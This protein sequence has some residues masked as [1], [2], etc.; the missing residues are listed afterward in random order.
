[1]SLTSEPIDDSGLMRARL[2]SGATGDP[3]VRSD[4]DNETETLTLATG[5]AVPAVL[6][7]LTH[8]DHIPGV[9]A[10]ADA[11]ATSSGAVPP[12]GPLESVDSMS[13]T[14]LSMD[15]ADKNPLNNG[16]FM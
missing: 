8:N 4:N 13:A 5:W 3:K 16:S 9:E 15:N 2:D 1:M 6:T 11:T 7:L 10:S 14:N 12:A